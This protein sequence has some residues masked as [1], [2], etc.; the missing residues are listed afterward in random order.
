MEGEVL[1][2]MW[3][4]DHGPNVS[5]LAPELILMKLSLTSNFLNVQ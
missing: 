4:N 5:Y 1:R 2:E 3:G